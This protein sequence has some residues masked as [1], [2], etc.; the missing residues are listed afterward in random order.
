MIA[1]KFKG[2]VFGEHSGARQTQQTHTPYQDSQFDKQ[3]PTLRTPLIPP[4]QHSSWLS[5]FRKKL[6]S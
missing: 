2:P 6:I 3:I 1:P 4:G 5:L